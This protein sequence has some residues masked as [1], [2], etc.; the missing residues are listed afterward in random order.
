MSSIQTAQSTFRPIARPTTRTIDAPSTVKS[1]LI[2][3]AV[4][5][6][7]VSVALLVLREAVALMAQD[8]W[9]IGRFSGS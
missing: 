3:F 7:L 9:M 4:T 2:A 6:V 5:V 1:D 8:L